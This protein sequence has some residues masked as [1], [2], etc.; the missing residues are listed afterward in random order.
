MLNLYYRGTQNLMA[1]ISN[2][3]SISMCYGQKSLISPSPIEGEE[4]IH[5]TATQ[6]R[7]VASG[8]IIL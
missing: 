3:S 1:L 7:F 4:I 2:G 6:P 5:A 8:N